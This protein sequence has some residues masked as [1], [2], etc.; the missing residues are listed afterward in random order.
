MTQRKVV[1]WYRQVG[2][3]ADAIAAARRVREEVDELIESLERG[4]TDNARREAADVGL[5]LLVAAETISCDLDVEMELK[6]YANL[7]RR[8]RV[9]EDGTLYHIKDSAPEADH[10]R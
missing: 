10:V 7:N 9:M 8:W 4:D 1:D 2:G 6:H 3:H 5:C